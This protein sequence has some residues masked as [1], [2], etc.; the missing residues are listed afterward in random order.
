[1]SKNV[2]P[3]L[4]KKDNTHYVEKTPVEILFITCRRTKS[5]ND[6]TFVIFWKLHLRKMQN[7][8]IFWN[9]RK[10]MN[11]ENY[12]PITFSPGGIFFQTSES[13]SP[14]G[15]SVD[16]KL[17]RDN[18]RVNILSNLGFCCFWWVSGGGVSVVSVL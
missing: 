4:S 1:M 9:C 10:I 15:I 6:N 17:Y 3:Y 18:S 2:L 7:L 16:R 8:V 13:N 11:Q 12:D 5:N 14:P